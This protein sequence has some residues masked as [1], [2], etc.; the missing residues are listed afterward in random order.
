MMRQF[1]E[2]MLQRQQSNHSRN[3]LYKF[4]IF[5][6]LTGRINPAHIVPADTELVS[7]RIKILQEIQLY[8]EIESRTKISKYECLLASTNAL[9][10][11][12]PSAE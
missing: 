12:G 8:T 5:R 7:T 4:S 1:T 6:S 2:K 11:F 9:L 3:H 10:C